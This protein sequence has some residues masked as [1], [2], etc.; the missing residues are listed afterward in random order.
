[1]CR[2][3][4]NR[5][6]LVCLT[7]AIAL[8]AVAVRS[9][10]RHDSIVWGW[11]SPA[12]REV[13]SWRISSARGRLFVCRGGFRD[14]RLDAER[15]DQRFPQ[16]VYNGTPS[17]WTGP[18]WQIGRESDFLG[19]NWIRHVPS[20]TD[21]AYTMILPLWL[22]IALFAA[23]PLA[24]GVRWVVAVRRKRRHGLCP[25]CGYDLRASPERCPECGRPRASAD[26]KRTHADDD[27]GDARGALTQDIGDSFDRSGR[28][29]R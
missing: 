13:Q 18:E 24:R 25:G 27:P 3:W 16:E 26:G 15:F 29:L 5:V 11:R 12:E 19:F 8:A 4:L 23:M 28:P 14:R 9:Y 22:P 7:V 17:Y 1:M 10:W 20:A 21:W 2:R 6:S